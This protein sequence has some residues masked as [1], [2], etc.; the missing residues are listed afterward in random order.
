M[1]EEIISKIQSHSKQVFQA[2]LIKNDLENFIP[3]LCSSS[4]SLR[5]NAEQ[6]ELMK[7]VENFLEDERYKVLLL[8][9]NAGG[10]KTFFIRYLQ[11]QLWFKPQV[12]SN[13]LIPIVIDL[14]TSEG[15]LT[16]F[17]D[18]AFLQNGL[19]E[20]DLKNLK[21]SQY[22]RFLFILDGFHEL[23][24][25]MNLSSHEALS[26]WPNSKVMV[27]ARTDLLVSLGTNNYKKYFDFFEKQNAAEQYVEYYIRPFTIDQQK[28][29]FQK[30]IGKN[31]GM[32][33]WEPTLNALEETGVPGVSS[34]LSNP[35]TLRIIGEHITDVLLER[36]GMFAKIT[37]AA[38]YT[39]YVTS[40]VLKASLLWEQQ[41]QEQVSTVSVASTATTAIDIIPLPM[42][43]HQYGTIGLQILAMLVAGNMFMTNCQV[44]DSL[45]TQLHIP[46]HS[47]QSLPNEEWKAFVVDMKMALVFSERVSLILKRKGNAFTFQHPSLYEY[48]S[49]KAL[50]E[51]LLIV[52]ND[53]S[54]VVHLHESAFF[55]QQSLRK[56]AS[57]LQLLVEMIGD[58]QSTVQSAGIII[59]ALWRVIDQSKNTSSYA[60]AAGNALTLLVLFKVSF[61]RRDLRDIRVYGATLDSHIFEEVNFN[62]AHFTCT[63]WDGVDLHH[64]DFTNCIFQ[65]NHLKER[66]TLT[67]P[68]V[69]SIYEIHVLTKY[70]I[71]LGS[72]YYPG[73]VVWQY[74]QRIYS[75]PELHGCEIV[76]SPNQLWVAC[77]LQEHVWL[78]SVKNKIIVHD[79]TEVHNLAQ[80]RDDGLIYYKNE[81]AY[82][83]YYKERVK[84]P[85][86]IYEKF[87]DTPEIAELVLELN[88]ELK[89]VAFC[90]DLKDGLKACLYKDDLGWSIVG[91]FSLTI[92]HG[93]KN[94]FSLYEDPDSK[95]NKLTFGN[96]K[97]FNYE[98]MAGISQTP[99]F[100]VSNTANIIYSFDARTLQTL[101]NLEHLSNYPVEKF[102]V[103]PKGNFLLIK[104][105]KT[106]HVLSIVCNE[107]HPASPVTI[108]YLYTMEH[109]RNEITTEQ[110]SADEKYIVWGLIGQVVVTKTTEN[111][112]VQEVFLREKARPVIMVAF[113]MTPEYNEEDKVANKDNH[114]QK[115]LG[116]ATEAQLV[117]L[118]DIVSEVIRLKVE[119]DEQYED[120]VI[121]QRISDTS[122][123]TDVKDFKETT[124]SAAAAAATVAT[125]MA[126]DESV[127]GEATVLMELV[128]IDETEKKLEEESK[129][130][131]VILDPKKEKESRFIRRKFRALRK[132]IEQEK[133]ATASETDAMEIVDS[134]SNIAPG[135]NTIDHLN[136]E[137]S[138]ALAT[139]IVQNIRKLDFSLQ[140]VMAQEIEKTVNALLGETFEEEDEH[141]SSKLLTKERA[142]DAW[143]FDKSHEI[144]RKN[145]EIRAMGTIFVGAQFMD[146]D[147]SI[148]QEDIRILKER[149]GIFDD[150]STLIAKYKASTDKHDKEDLILL[151][152]SYRY[153][154]FFESEDV[155]WDKA[156]AFERNN[157]DTLIHFVVRQERHDGDYE[158]YLRFLI[159]IV[160][161]PF[162]AGNKN[163]MSPL[164]IAARKGHGKTCTVLLEAN[165]NVNQPAI[166]GYTPLYIASLEGHVH[167]CKLLLDAKAEVDKHSDDGYFPL[168]VAAQEGREDVCRLLIKYGANIT[169]ADNDGFTPLYLACQHGFDI[170]LRVLIEEGHADVNQCS[171]EGFPPLYIASQNGHIETMRLL[172]KSG[173]QV[174]LASK[175]G[176]TPILTAAQHGQI[177]ATRLLIAHGGNVNTAD[178][179]GFSP[180]Y[181]AASNNG[182]DQIC[183]MLV[184]AG[185]KPD[186]PNKDEVAPLYVAS[187]NGHEAV[188]KY[189]LE[190]GADV[191]RPTGTGCTP[192]Y[193]ASYVGHSG[194]VQFF[195]N[196]KGIE[197]NKANNEG[198]SPLYGASRNGHES[199]VDMLMEHGA[200][201]L[202]EDND[203]DTPLYI[204][205]MHGHTSICTK[206]ISKGGEVGKVDQNGFFPIYVCAQNGHT[207]V[208]RLLL[209]HGANP[210]QLS[211]EGFSGL[212]VASQNGHYGVCE[213]LL[214]SGADANFAV[215]GSFTCF[216]I[217]AKNGHLDVCQLLVAHKADFNLSTESGYTP[218]YIAADNNRPEVC[219]YLIEQGVNVNRATNDG[220][221]ALYSAAESGYDDV[222]RVLLEGGADVNYALHGG[223]P[224]LYIAAQ[225]GYAKVC[226]LLLDYGANIHHLTTGGYCPLYIASDYRHEETCRTLIDRMNFIP[227]NCIRAATTKFGATH[228]IVKLMQETNEVGIT[229]GNQSAAASATAAAN[230]APAGEDEAGAGAELNFDD[231]EGDY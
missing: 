151:A 147:G 38:V 179:E 17:I 177:E 87:D 197:V 127:S 111:T 142:I 86:K 161:I 125:P 230:G 112:V 220:F 119:I 7:K 90:V 99:F 62:G 15:S 109:I 168:Y 48:F 136:S 103:S 58:H 16:D 150:E 61:E 223:F 153:R 155:V 146:Q 226:T 115:L 29:F 43:Y 2:A 124:S 69:G 199:I 162:D 10:G 152:A 5:K 8:H 207:D 121:K 30:C 214:Q 68:V 148:N 32:S 49:A 54:H 57:I 101:L 3:L 35:F 132:Q 95:K 64:C 91:T 97:T 170:A 209:L 172:I 75:N 21:T 163:L 219:K 126:T 9:G 104:N 53:E 110:F 70:H 156:T 33:E 37:R 81:K 96:M 189:L 122:E 46:F 114:D 224:S 202:Q 31:Y 11:N 173:A 4:Y 59:D 231:A 39:H 118:Q 183:R 23:S 204:A 221:V 107:E 140:E 213:A 131:A 84:D 129:I 93:K 44:I 78:Y 198:Y 123:K 117:V 18:N 182:H 228:E 171:N 19:T 12:H 20:Q 144:I 149:G 71:V 185:A 56:Q 190:Q 55:N 77:K 82:F 188:C 216:Y 128:T 106:V 208:C 159:H 200:N 1:I 100:L 225:R 176:S 36:T 113:L 65:E 145:A 40:T 88:K 139:S 193:I 76:I 116:N 212:Y 160:K 63:S 92:N 169:K 102:I 195:L 229:P 94:F 25:P 158:D 217:A 79:I 166:G 133:S 181:L 74:G 24:V 178:D 108:S 174:N 67:S 184:E 52:A 72:G 98:M 130:G 215:H 192:L 143:A 138:R 120:K 60:I 167:V 191:N 141:E 187:E 194:I 51:E 205:S 157:N 89:E 105:K 34:I 164:Y 83:L 47:L 66:A 154:L 135:D 227:Q 73:F 175:D 137:S 186:Q 203:G 80:V 45:Q 206:L 85:R 22:D 196:T 28:S 6:F 14:S 180:L 26:S 27:T 165:A 218:L 201:V 50:F 13:F 210:N 222:C 211:S 42:D 134:D 41:Q